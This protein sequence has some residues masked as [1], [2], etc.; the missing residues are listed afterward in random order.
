MNLTVFL[1][2]FIA[3]YKKVPE[4]PGTFL[5]ISFMLFFFDE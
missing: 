2:L 4:I 1:K 3:R 5:L